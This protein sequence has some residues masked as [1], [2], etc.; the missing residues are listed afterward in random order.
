[1][2]DP[3]YFMKNYVKIVDPKKG[4][5]TFNLFEYQEEMVLNIH[6]NKDTVILAS[7]QL[8]KCICASAQ[9][10]TVV[11]PTGLRKLILKLIDRTTYDILFGSSDPEPHSQNGA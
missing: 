6:E 4:A 2:A 9:L 8:G 7:R 1:M 10:N 3:I 5:T 11:R